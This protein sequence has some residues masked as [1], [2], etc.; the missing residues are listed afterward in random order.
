[1]GKLFL[2]NF[3]WERMLIEAESIQDAF[4]FVIEDKG[5]YSDPVVREIHREE[6]FGFSRNMPFVKLYGR[7]DVNIENMLGLPNKD[8]FGGYNCL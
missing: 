6:L 3:G 2:V 4:D 1:M 7:K 8:I 5:V